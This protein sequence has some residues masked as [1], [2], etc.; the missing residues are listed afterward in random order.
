MKD[1]TWC[2]ARLGTLAKHSSSYGDWARSRSAFI[3]RL[4]TFNVDPAVVEAVEASGDHFTAREV[5]HAL[6][7]LRQ[8]VPSGAALG[9]LSGTFWVPVP[10]HPLWRAAGFNRILKDMCSEPQ[11]RQMLLAAGKKTCDSG[12]LLDFRVAWQLREPGVVAVCKDVETVFEQ[13]CS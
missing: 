5:R 2:R 6:P 10:Y 12:E 4:R 8:P 9:Y 11:W 13:A 3:D 1:V 7:P